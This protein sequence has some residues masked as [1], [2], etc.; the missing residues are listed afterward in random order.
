MQIYTVAE[1]AKILKC[2]AHTVRNLIIGGSLLANNITPYS[3]KGTFRVT[4]SQLDLFLATP[5]QHPEAP[6]APPIARKQFLFVGK[7]KTA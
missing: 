2:S 4:Q 3:S 6:K 1:V 5:F 7:D